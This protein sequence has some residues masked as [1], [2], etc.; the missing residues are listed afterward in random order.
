M[1]SLA[2]LSLMAHH[3]AQAAQLAAL[4]WLVEL[5]QSQERRFSVARRPA[6]FLV[7]LS[8]KTFSATDLL[9][10]LRSCRDIAS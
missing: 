7:W 6:V 1:V 2:Q 8:S 3:S 5:Y 4:S 9:P 10:W